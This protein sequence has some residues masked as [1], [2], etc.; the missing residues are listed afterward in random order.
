MTSSQSQNKLNNNFQHDSMSLQQDTAKLQHHQQFYSPYQQQSLDQS[1]QNQTVPP[2]IMQTQ[3]QYASNM[4]HQFPQQQQ[5]NTSTIQSQFPTHPPQLNQQAQIQ[6][7]L[8]EQQQQQQYMLQQ[9]F[10]QQQQQQSNY[11]Q[12]NPYSKPMAH[13]YPTPANIQQV[14]N[15]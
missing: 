5:A 12:A 6:S 2:P 13:R 3:Q 9:Q 10:L 8:T 11:Q 1:Q 14:Y 15:K 4:F 7:G